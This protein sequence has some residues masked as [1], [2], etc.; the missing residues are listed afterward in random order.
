MVVDACVLKNP[1][2]QIKA[3]NQ[4]RGV[5]FRHN[6]FKGD[7]SPRYGGDGAKEAVAPGG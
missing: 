5:L 4:A 1:A 3:D 7:P 2:S 6:T